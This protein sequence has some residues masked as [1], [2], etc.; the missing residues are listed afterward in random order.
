MDTEKQSGERI[1]LHILFPVI[2]VALLIIG[3]MIRFL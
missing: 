2:Y 1:K 3:L